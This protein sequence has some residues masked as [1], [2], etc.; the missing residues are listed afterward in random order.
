MSTEL[1]ET[2]RGFK[3]IIEESVCQVGHLPEIYKGAQSEKKKNKKKNECLIVRELHV[4]REA[5]CS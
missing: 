3:Y 5:A 2:C 4:L 1:L